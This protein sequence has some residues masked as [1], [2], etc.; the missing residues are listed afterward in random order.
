MFKPILHFISSYSLAANLLLLPL[1]S[2]IIIPVGMIS[3]LLAPLPVLM[4]LILKPLVLVLNALLYGGSLLQDWLPGSRCYLSTL[5]TLEMLLAALFIFTVCWLLSYPR[6]KKSGLLL[7]VFLSFAGLLN[8][9]WWWHDQAREKLGLAAFVG[10]KPQSLLFEMP[11]GEALLINGGSWG[12]SGTGSFFSMAEKV[13]APYCWR[14]KIKRIDTLILTEPQR[15]LVGGLLF[16]VEHFKV[17]EIWYHGIWSGY[18]PFRNFC[19]MSQERFG[20][21]WHKLSSLS[22][23]F[24]LNGVDISVL[25]PPAN[26]FI[27]LPSR[28]ASLLA[29][30]PSLLLRYGDFSA[31][32]WGGGQID[33]ASL[34]T[35]VNL[36]ALLVNPAERLPEVLEKVAIKAGGWYLEPG[37]WGVAVDEKIPLNWSTAHSWR[38]KKDGFLFL[39]ADLSGSLSNKLPAQLI[40]GCQ[41]G[42]E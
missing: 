6:Y 23:P 7:L 37:N 15:G 39:K 17:R 38:V 2:F 19:R 10:G 33:P 14:R 16:L 3:L 20:V 28:K 9:G 42:L 4:T 27:F 18:P 34:P 31:L 30:A 22:F 32:I 5:T 35:S 41:G 13:I 21:R 24:R 25:G 11:G 40:S 12:G 8:R 26:D 1:F 36:M 29:M